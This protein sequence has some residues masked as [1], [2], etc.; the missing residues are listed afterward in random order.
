MG[1]CTKMTRAELLR[2]VQRLHAL[3]WKDRQIGLAVD[4]A[5]ETI[6]KCRHELELP[7]LENSEKDYF[8]NDQN[9]W[10]SPEQTDLRMDLYGDKRY[11]RS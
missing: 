11:D 10:E 2:A 3:G 9:R 8:R 6:K 1:M 7:S 5:S 4:R